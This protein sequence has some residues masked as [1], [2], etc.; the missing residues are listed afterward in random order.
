MT[1]LTQTYVKMADVV[2]FTAHEAIAQKRKYTGDPYIVHPR[3]VA[4]IVSKVDDCAWHQ[5]CVALLHDVVE[6]TELTN[7]HIEELFGPMIAKGV[8]YLTN[9]E[10][11]AGNRA[12]RFELNLQRISEA[13]RAVKTVKIADLIENTSTI[14]EHDPHFA[15]VYLKEKRELLKRALIGGDE[16]LWKQ[17]FDHCNDELKKL[18]IIG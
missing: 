15:P 4:D 14:V 2:A 18:G 6:D 3:A 16:K 13:P 10:K 9:V 7:Q 12:E 17:A 11:S 1:L 8:W 5:I